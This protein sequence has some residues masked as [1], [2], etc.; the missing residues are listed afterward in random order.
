L[1]RGTKRQKHEVISEDELAIM[2]LKI[3][4]Y[5]HNANA[6]SFEEAI[7]VSGLTMEIIRMI[8]DYYD[9]DLSNYEKT[10]Y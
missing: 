4:C 10:R 6:F 7:K 9:S 8:R 1:L 5:E 3:L 2:K